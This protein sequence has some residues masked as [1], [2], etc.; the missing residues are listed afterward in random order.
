MIMDKTCRA[1]FCD[2]DKYQETL[3]K[4]GVIIDLQ[5]ITSW[6][7]REVKDKVSVVL[8]LTFSPVFCSHGLCV[9]RWLTPTQA[10]GTVLDTCVQWQTDL[11]N[12]ATKSSLN[13]FT[14]TV[15]KRTKCTLKRSRCNS[16]A[17][18]TCAVRLSDLQSVAEWAVSWQLALACVLTL[19]PLAAWRTLPIY[20]GNLYKHI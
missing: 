19:A 12:P 16:A 2:S 1:L 8:F 11:I 18:M 3:W 5:S 14:A 13:T 17:K 10:A 9:W 6:Y 7:W 20:K 15:F 4:H